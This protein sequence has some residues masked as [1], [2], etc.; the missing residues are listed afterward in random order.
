MNIWPF[1]IGHQFDSTQSTAS[2]IE[3]FEAKQMG[4][5]GCF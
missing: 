2:R 4:S 1:L 3:G 5:L